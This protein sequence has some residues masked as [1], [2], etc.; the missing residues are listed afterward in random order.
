MMKF[1][2]KA[3]PVGYIDSKCHNIKRL[4][5]SKGLKHILFALINCPRDTT[6]M[7]T[8]L[9]SM[10]THIMGVQHLQRYY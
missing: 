5:S 6:G 2:T 1:V 3:T 7:T 4:K 8:K 9:F 10:N